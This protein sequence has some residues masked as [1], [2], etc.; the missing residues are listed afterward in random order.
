MTPNAHFHVSAMKII[1][2]PIQIPLIV[3]V[4]M[5]SIISLIVCIVISC[6]TFLQRGSRQG[7]PPPWLSS[8]QEVLVVIVVQIGEVIFSAAVTTE[9]RAV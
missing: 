7:S 9:R 8:G 6:A 3:A 4:V 5:P 1:Q 2:K